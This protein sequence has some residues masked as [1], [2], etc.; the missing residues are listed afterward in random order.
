MVAGNHLASHTWTETQTTTSVATLAHTAKHEHPRGC[1]EHPTPQKEAPA[2]PQGLAH[3]VGLR[4]RSVPASPG[5]RV[6]PED[7]VDAH[8]SLA[9]DSRVSICSGRRSHR[10][11]PHAIL[12]FTEREVDQLSPLTQDPVDGALQMGRGRSRGR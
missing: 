6:R 8:E 9:H 7:A 11:Q 2:W 5:T 4:E 10:G 3:H 1:K 12:A